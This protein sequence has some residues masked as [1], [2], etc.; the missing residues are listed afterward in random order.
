MRTGRFNTVGDGGGSAYGY[1]ASIAP[2]SSNAYNNNSS[3][4]NINNGMV[5][6]NNSSGGG[7]SVT[8]PSQVRFGA[9]STPNDNVPY[10][11][12]MFLFDDEWEDGDDGLPQQ[13]QGIPTE[14]QL[15]LLCLDY[16]RDLRRSYSSSSNNNNG[17]D[18]VDDALAQAEGIDSDYLSLAIWALSRSFVKPQ[19]LV[20]ERAQ[21]ET[22]QLNDVNAPAVMFAGSRRGTRSKKGAK[23]EVEMKV[24]GGGGLS[25]V[26]SAGIDYVQAVGNDA[27]FRQLPSSFNERSGRLLNKE[28][29]GDGDNIDGVAISDKIVIPTMEEIT[30]EVLLRHPTEKQ[31]SDE[32]GEPTG[33][34]YNDAHYSNAH[35]FYLLNGLASGGNGGSS[36]NTKATTS[37]ARGMLFPNSNTG[38]G[39]GPLSFTEIALAGLWSLGAKARIDAERTMVMHNPLFE[40]FVKAASSKGFF[41]EKK[42]DM[43]GSGGGG[44]KSS[45]SSVA[46]DAPVIPEVALT[47]EEEERKAR[48]LYEEKYRKVVAKFRS[49]LAVK[50]EGQQVVPITVMNSQL[51]HQ[52]Y[53]GR[54]GQMV[55]GNASVSSGGESLSSYNHFSVADRQRRRREL[56]IDQAKMTREENSGVHQQQKLQPPKQQDSRFS[57][58]S[59]SAQV[60]SYAKSPQNKLPTFQQL[61]SPT[62]TSPSVVSPKSNHHTQLAEQLNS[63][64]NLLMQQ[65]QFEQALEAYTAA[66]QQSPAGCNSHVYYSNRAAAYLSLNNYELSIRDSQRALSLKP[67]YAKAHSRLG[68]AYFVSE[69]YEEAVNAYEIAL[70]Y[71]PDNEWNRSH[72]E[73]AVTKL[74]EMLMERNATVD[75]GEVSGPGRKGAPKD[76][77]GSSPF[78]E[79]NAEEEG[80]VDASTTDSAD[81]SSEFIQTREADLHKDSGNAHM[82]SKE[83]EKALQHYTEAISISHTGPNSHVYYSNRAAAFC[84]LGRYDAAVNDCMASIELNPQYEKAHARLGLSRFFMGDYRGAIEAYEHALELDPKSAASLSYLGKAKTRLA[85]QEKAE[86]EEELR[87]QMEEK[88][89]LQQQMERIQ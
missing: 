33:Y 56:R 10:D 66:L 42:D 78:D 28:L 49:K 22:V 77:A 50:A 21:V 11:P 62:A 69:R 61:E 25:S 12:P 83:Y 27:W 46:P 47:P 37:N 48:M 2:S 74:E 40:Q 8:S 58:D 88:L 65:K 75:G 16:L 32:E 52:Q 59:Q 85:D 35:R 41:N 14:A 3:Q 38:S 17:D 34:E 87:R 18:D 86:E 24:L 29:H 7:P 68:L 5:Q 45:S 39:G 13:Q 23:K 53:H 43:S 20:F 72:Y 80:V 19:K 82:S 9:S 4:Y 79:T 84:Y 70:E 73:K 36:R 1:S 54:G 76:P 30:N 57:F 55:S 67:E 64:G 63:D 44:R 31:Q 71:E 89:A 26:A 51:Q 6:Y 60:K 81:R 15:T